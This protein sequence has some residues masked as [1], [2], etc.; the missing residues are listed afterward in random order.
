MRKL[1]IISCLC[2]AVAAGLYAVLSTQASSRQKVPDVSH[3][4][5]HLEIQRLEQVLFGL[6]N[7]EAIRAFLK[8]NTLFATQ[9]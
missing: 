7:K 3:I 6:D 4:T 2:I 1:V 9:F 5:V 8:D